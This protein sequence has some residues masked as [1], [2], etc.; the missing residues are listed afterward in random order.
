LDGV[1]HAREPHGPRAGAVLAVP[2]DLHPLV[3]RAVEEDLALA[4][5]QVLPGLVER[6]AELARDGVGDVG[7]P[8]RVLAGALA[9]G[10]DRAF[11]D[12][13]APVGDDQVGVDL[14]AG[15]EA[16]AVDAH[17]ERAV[18]R[19]RL[20]RQLGQADAAVGAGARLAVGALARLALDGDQ[21]RAAA[22]LH[23]RLDR[24]GQPR[25]VGR[26]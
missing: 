12:R 17:A 18:E 8:A 5:R 23:R 26:I 24:V 13:E 19:E 11:A 21:H 10:L 20:R 22:H 1:D 9:P 6:D 15:A 16:V 7:R 3:T 2:G 14:H 4:R 25:A